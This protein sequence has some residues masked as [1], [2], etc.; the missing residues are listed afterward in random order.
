MTVASTVAGQR[1]GAV[2]SPQQVYFTHCRPEDSVTGQ[3]GYSIRAAS[4]RDAELLRFITASFSYELPLD[5]VR[6]AIG[7][8]MAP[9]R[10]ARV[11]A[12]G[13]RVALVHTAHLPEDTVGRK[14]SF[15]SHVLVF[16]ALSPLQALMT[17]GSP[18]W[19][20]TYPAGSPKELPSLAGPPG[21]GRINDQVLTEFL[22]PTPK[23]DP[24]LATLTCPGRLL[25]EQTQR[26]DLLR[27]VIN[28]CHRVMQAAE[29]EP[30]NRLYLLGEPGL[31]ALLLYGAVRLLPREMAAELTFSTYENSHRSL[32]EYRL[33]R[34]VGTY[35][36]T[37][38][39]K[40]L[41]PDFYQT[42]GYAI[43][44]F[45]IQSS[46]ELQRDVSPA[47]ERLVDLAA[48]GEYALIDRAYSVQGQGATLAGFT[49]GIRLLEL[50]AK[51]A[52][53]EANAAALLELRRTPAGRAVL[54]NYPNEVWT[55]VRDGCLSNEPLRQEFADVLAGHLPELV[56]HAAR[57]LAAD[58]PADWQQH[59][60]L[61]K[62]LS[63]NPRATFLEILPS[64]PATLAVLRLPLL[65][66]WN[67]LAAPGDKLPSPLDAFLGGLRPDELGQMAKIGLP[68]PWQAFALFQ[69]LYRTETADL[70]A[71][72]V[73]EADEA[74]FAGV[75]ETIS[76]L[77][78][79]D[80]YPALHQLAPPGPTAPAL[81]GRLLG[82]RSTFASQAI[83]RLLLGLRAYDRTWLPFWLES[84]RIAA[85]LRLPSP[86]G[87]DPLWKPFVSFIDRDL[88]VAGDP[89]QKAL[90]SYLKQA[91]DQSSGTPA[92]IKQGLTDW[93]VLRQ[94]FE[95]PENTP[96]GSDEQ[97]RETCQRCGVS[98]LELVRDYFHHAVLPHEVGANVLEPC[99]AIFHG[100]LPAMKDETAKAY[101]IRVRNWQTVTKGCPDESKR[102]D[103]LRYYVEKHVEEAFWNVVAKEGPDFRVVVEQIIRQQRAQRLLEQQ[104][105][106]GQAAEAAS[107]GEGGEAPDR[108]QN[109]QAIDWRG[110]LPWVGVCTALILVAWLV[111][112]LSGRNRS[113]RIETG[114]NE[115]AESK[116]N[117]KSEEKGAQVDPRIEEWKNK[118]EKVPTLEARLT[119]WQSA[120]ANRAQALQARGEKAGELL[121][122]IKSESILLEAE[123]KHKGVVWKERIEKSKDK[124][125]QWNPLEVDRIESE[126]RQFELGVRT[127]EIRVEID[128]IKTEMLDDTSRRRLETLREKVIALGK[129]LNEDK[130]ALDDSEKKVIEY[131]SELLA[132]QQTV[133]AKGRNGSEEG[134][135]KTRAALLRV[136]Q[137][138]LS[139]MTSDT[140]ATRVC[141]LGP[142]QRKTIDAALEKLL[143]RMQRKDPSENG[144][145]LEIAIELVH[146]FHTRRGYDPMKPLQ[147]DRKRK[148][149][150]AI[151]N[152]ANELK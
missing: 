64:A 127:A 27:L 103:Y 147:A 114:G 128:R 34:V 13:G 118:A 106:A 37:P 26:R 84:G 124:D 19:A 47:V 72:L 40:G 151:A 138:L 116:A 75:C 8:G 45:S 80:Q 141:P 89:A 145:A 2:S 74:V 58:S 68:P 63:K 7:P 88:L 95:H 65:R 15:F 136:H 109:K 133:A 137:E 90:L 94:H 51:L 44:T 144:P 18:E 42:R 83:S 52:R 66:E 55:I 25:K 102:R 10:L 5:M 76:R 67:S 125:G 69:A 86:N 57:V 107:V 14:N 117:D 131:H 33:A 96:A 112:Y 1:P 9:T 4:T 78:P 81:L 46:T 149:L 23:A 93:S 41:N 87:G 61:V 38:Q 20:A 16:P 108:Q 121:K 59:W 29:S 21:H 39:E 85:L 62:S 101:K 113:S 30:R 73:R 105:R 31:I 11:M 150:L 143:L 54:N 70:A 97:L 139:M 140:F 129:G 91:G 50:H 77:A 82:S 134:V 98:G 99:I 71:H 12:P 32:R 146:F 49:E 119:R 36:S 60:G 48:R 135:E 148:E 3:A 110:R 6:G 43:D 122:S 130:P 115:I 132:L 126:I 53:G 120:G 104:A 24:N 100:F 35:S 28:G 56:Q 142:M 111:G 152:R 92:A 123:P 17:W 79:A 22:G